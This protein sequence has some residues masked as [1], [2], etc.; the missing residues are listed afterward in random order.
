[1]FQGNGDGMFHPFVSA[2]LDLGEFNL[3]GS[4]G[5][6]QPVDNGD[7]SSSLDYHLH[8]SYEIAERFFPLIEVNGISYTSDGNLSTVN[9]EGTDLINL[10]SDDVDGNNVI[11]GAIGGRVEL[12]ADVL[13]GTAYEFPLTSRRDLYGWRAYADLMFIF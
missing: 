13:F 11:T 4:I 8:L 10:G 9:F 6:N 5:Y 12:M 7:E 1:M 3:V 2:G